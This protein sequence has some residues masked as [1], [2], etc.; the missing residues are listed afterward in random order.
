[1]GAEGGDAEEGESEGGEKSDEGEEPDEEEDGSLRLSAAAATR[2]EN[3]TES[4][5]EGNDPGRRCA[6]E[7]GKTRSGRAVVS[8]SGESKGLVEEEESLEECEESGMVGSLLANLPAESLGRLV[9]L[10]IRWATKSD[11]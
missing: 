3:E 7:E 4:S 10:G 5:E 9:E 8:D 2:R 1:M 11:Q 6:S